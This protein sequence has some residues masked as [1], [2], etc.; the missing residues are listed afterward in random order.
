MDLTKRKTLRLRARLSMVL[1]IAGIGVVLLMGALT[2]I[3]GGPFAPDNQRPT[4]VVA[5]TT[6]PGVPQT[7]AAPSASP[8]MKATPYQ[9]GGWSGMGTFKGGDWPGP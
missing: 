5:D 9:G 2:L 6:T 8:T 4:G 3:I 7:S 1:A